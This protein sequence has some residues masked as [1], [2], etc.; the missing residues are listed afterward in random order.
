MSTTGELPADAP[1]FAGLDLA[2]AGPVA[3][4]G[5][6]QAT[7][8]GE[9]FWKGHLRGKVQAQCRRCLAEV[10]L[11]VDSDIGLMFSSD[12]DVQAD[13]SVHE[14]APAATHID[15]AELVREELV[16]AV[17]EYPL[18]RPDCAGLCPRCGADLNTGPCAVHGA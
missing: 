1:T 13:P 15:L 8:D 11:M 3:V 12:P 18:C 4:D 5:R 17:P 16:L 14:L 6:I 9:Y 2:L 7:G 10:A